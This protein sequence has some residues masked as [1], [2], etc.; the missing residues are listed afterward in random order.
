VSIH[1]ESAF[2]A[3][4]EAHLIGHG[5]LRLDPAAYDRGLGL[6]GDE[7]VAYVETSQP[8]AWQQLVTRHGGEAMAR[9]KFLKVVAD[10]LDHRGTISVLRA[11]ASPPCRV[12]S[13]CQ[14]F[15]WLVST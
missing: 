13:C 9:S 8:K 15:G 6:F 11:I 4:I 5:W 7:V 14:A 3:N 1:Q 12:T 2:E 10:A